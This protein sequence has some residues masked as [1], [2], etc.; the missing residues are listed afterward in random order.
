MLDIGVR[1]LLLIVL[2][3]A[4][5]HAISTE[6]TFDFNLDFLVTGGGSGDITV[7]EYPH[8][9]SG[10]TGYCTSDAIS[11]PSNDLTLSCE[12]YTYTAR[13]ISYETYDVSDLTQTD[14]S[15]KNLARSL[16]E[17]KLE[18]FDKAIAIASWIRNNVDYDLGVGETQ[19]TGKW[20]Y[21]NKIGTCDE[22]SHLF[23]AL[24]RSVGLTAR[25][26]SGY[27]YNGE[28]WLP[29]AWAEVWTRYGWAPIDIAFDEYGYVD[30]THITV[31][32][33][34]DGDHNFILIYYFGD[35]SVDHSFDISITE[36][37][38][39]PF[40]TGVSTLNTSGGVYTLVELDLQ[41]PFPT[42]IALFPN[43]ILPQGFE[44]KQ[45][46][47][48]D[49]VIL[50]SGKNKAHLVFEIPKI[51][52]GYFY[53]IPL[54]IYFGSEGV[55]TSFTVTENQ[56]CSPLKEIE[57][58]VYDTSGCTSLDTKGLASSN[59]TR[60]D[61]FCGLCYYSIEEPMSRSYQL[62]YPDFCEGNCTLGVEVIGTGP[63]ELL[64]NG[65]D[66]SGFAQ[67]YEQL[68]IP[69]LVGNNTVDIDGVLR[70]LEIK[71]PPEPTLS[72]ELKDDEVCFDSNWEIFENCKLLSCGENAIEIDLNYGSSM[73]S[74]EKDITRNC[75]FWERLI[76]FIQ[77]FLTN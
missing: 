38:D 36:S 72:Y 30:G 8:N 37:N 5:L 63:F 49:A 61:F 15:M 3:L 75:G 9:F 19:E 25:Y 23:I 53:T 14:S 66:Y 44:I 17:G 76:H 56:E 28:N 70:M 7:L 57:P 32:K 47:P 67:V 4:P 10:Q 33:D 6:A 46:Y 16:V 13:D 59:S 1:R 60:G 39:V 62:D 29:H 69:L 27:A 18:K 11:F 74:I 68:T 42:P 51:R 2:L 65:E 52:Q 50:N 77:G 55:N 54:T 12:V 31:H 48:N 45:I 43:I 73:R 24:S 20:T 64:V 58:F 26:V 35:A 40:I 22:L 41:N 34:V 21:Y 71:T